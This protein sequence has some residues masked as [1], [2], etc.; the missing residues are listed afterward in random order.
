[1]GV[2]EMSASLVGLRPSRILHQKAGDNL[3]AVGDPVPNFLQQHTVLTQGVFQLRRVGPGIGDVGSSYQDARL[4]EVQ[5]VQSLG[6]DE[7]AAGWSPANLKIHLAGDG[8]SLARR[9]GGQQA[10]QLRDVPFADSQLKKRPSRQVIGPGFEGLAE[11][12]AGGDDHELSVEKQERR[13]RGGDNR[14]GQA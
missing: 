10:A 2:V 5:I 13:R 8:R 1:M 4:L 14:Q 3:E 9:R 11:R 12:Q 7:Q 6:L